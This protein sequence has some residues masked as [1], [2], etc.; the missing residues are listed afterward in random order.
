MIV[1]DIQ[2]RLGTFEL[3]VQFDADHETV[4]LFGRSG[5]GKSRTL[6]AVAGL[7]RPDSGRIAIAGR[8]VYDGASRI[9]VAPQQRNLGLLFQ[10][11]A[12]FPHMT[13]DEN[14]AYPLTGWS[15][16]ARDRRVRELKELLRIEDLG[17]R[18]PAQLS[19]GQQ[20][21]VALARALARPVD[22]LLLDEPFSALDEG[23]RGDLRAELLRLRSDLDV[24]VICVTHDLREA[25]LLADRI[26]VI[27]A[28]RTLQFAPRG[29]VFQHPASRQV[30]ELTGVRNI[31]AARG[32]GGSRVELDGVAF[33]VATPVAAG[34]TLDVAIRSERCLLRRIEPGEA[35]PPNCF[36][37][38]I[39][40]ELAFGSTY[41]LRL[42]PVGPGPTVE[43]EVSSHPYDVLGIATRKRWVVELPA[44]D[45]HVMQAS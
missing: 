36:V 32:L 9:D 31:F 1:A 6:A 25:H 38:E 45:L 23:L 7:M 17:A 14:I 3:D 40:S 27:E 20:Q 8:T 39:T 33:E 24:P 11:I 18:Y 42:D 4:V 10:Q 5:S 28:G 22:G 12:V 41:T 30:A 29:E 35:L 44:N 19:G 13:A 37:A 21:R 43:A 26:A 15:A 16:E 34:A 2:K